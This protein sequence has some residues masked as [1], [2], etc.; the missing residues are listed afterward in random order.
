MRLAVRLVTPIFMCE[1]RE[2]QLKERRRTTSSRNENTIFYRI[3]LVH[4][5]ILH[6]SMN[7]CLGDLI[8]IY[9][10]R[11]LI[12]YLKFLFAHYYLQFTD[13]NRLLN[14]N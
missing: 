3:H 14:L 13:K 1:E 10:E 7:K 2:T 4:A 6:L 11:T 5:T 9:I 12:V 8:D